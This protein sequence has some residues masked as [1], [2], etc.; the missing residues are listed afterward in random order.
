MFRIGMGMDSHSFEEHQTDKPL[1]LGGMVIN[2]YRGLKGNSD[3]DVILHAL[4]N[5]ISQALGKRSIGFYCDPL[6]EHND[7]TSSEVYIR[8][9]LAWLNEDGYSIQN[10]GVT[11]ECRRPN[12][13]EYSLQLRQSLALILRLNEDQ[14]G[15]NATSG[16]D[17]T[18]FGLGKGI[19]VFAVVLLARNR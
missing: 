13:E 11:I 9:P 17:L 8:I 12:I 3:A 2:G 18:S 1:K 7:I 10:I 19:Q 4:F 14:I 15:I 6:Y 16:E 5:A